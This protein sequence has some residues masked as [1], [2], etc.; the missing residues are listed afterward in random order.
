[1]LLSNRFGWNLWHWYGFKWSVS[2]LVIVYEH[3][4]YN[5]RM[6][7]NFSLDISEIHGWLILRFPYNP[8]SRLE[9]VLA[10]LWR[11]WSSVELALLCNSTRVT[12]SHPMLYATRK[13]V[14]V[15]DVDSCHVS[16]NIGGRDDSR[17]LNLQRPHHFRAGR[18]SGL[19]F[20]H[21]FILVKFNRL[22]LPERVLKSQ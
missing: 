16:L 4:R 6:L 5:L 3:L 22:D 11:W 10:L 14:L 18:L 2:V 15:H 19:L 21:P 17:A 13:A 8:N 7:L 9:K 20:D 12:I 1:M